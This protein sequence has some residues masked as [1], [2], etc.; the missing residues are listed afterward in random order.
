MIYLVKQPYTLPCYSLMEPQEITIQYQGA[1]LTFHALSFIDGAATYYEI[2]KDGQL[3][4]KIYPEINEDYPA[5][6]WKSDEIPEELT[7]LIG[8]AIEKQDL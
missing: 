1:T 5:V 2:Y 8:D 4:G 3:L 6:D 7:R